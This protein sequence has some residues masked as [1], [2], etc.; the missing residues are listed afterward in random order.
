MMP[1]PMTLNDLQLLSKILNDTKHCASSLRQLS[2]LLKHNVVWEKRCASLCLARHSVHALTR[3]RCLLNTIWLHTSLAITTL[4]QHLVSIPFPRWQGVEVC[5]AWKQQRFSNWAT[6][7][8]S[9]PSLQE[10]KLK[11]LSC[12][13]E[14]VRCFVS[15]NVAKSLK[16][17]QDDWKWYHLKV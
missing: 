7:W 13:R 17:T 11:K 14:A 4:A 12:R 1:F 9:L 5:W 16:V 2:F 6:L 8:P 3:Q 10:S 15:L